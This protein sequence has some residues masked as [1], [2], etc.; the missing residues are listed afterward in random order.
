MRQYRSSES[1]NRSQISFVAEGGGAYRIELVNPSE[2]RTGY[3]FMIT[4]VT[5]LDVRLTAAMPDKFTSPTIEKVRK[6]MPGETKAFWRELVRRSGSPIVEPDEK[7]QRYQ[8]VTFL[9]KHTATTRNVVVLGPN[10][11]SEA[12]SENTMRRLMSSDVCISRSG[13]PGELGSHTGSH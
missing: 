12:P 5:S 6:Q 13:F 1:G 4:E 8:L 11:G 9:W 10:W 2:A 3:E 7:D